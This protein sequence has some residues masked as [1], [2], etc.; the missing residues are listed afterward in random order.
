MN[1]AFEVGTAA[2][3]PGERSFG[4]VEVARRS[5]DTVISIPIILVRGRRPGPIL[6]LSAG[7][8]ADEYAGRC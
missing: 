4:E 5:D 6:C 8:H 1:R 7:M 2:A 3:L